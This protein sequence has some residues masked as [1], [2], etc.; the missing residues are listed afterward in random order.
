LFHQSPPRIIKNHSNSIEAKNK[1][2]IEPFS[3]PTRAAVLAL[4]WTSH[5]VSFLLSFQEG[6][7]KDLIKL[8]LQMHQLPFNKGALRV[9]KLHAHRA[10]LPGDE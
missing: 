5:G 1:Y 6:N 9:G 3:I 10:E 4:T 2:F 7:L 8:A